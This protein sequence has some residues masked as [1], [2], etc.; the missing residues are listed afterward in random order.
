LP[1]LS[2]FSGN[3][4]STNL[5]PFKLETITLKQFWHTFHYVILLITEYYSCLFLCLLRGP[6]FVMPSALNVQSR[7]FRKNEL[8][9]RQWGK[10]NRALEATIFKRI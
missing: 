6:Y 3:S 4:F 9:F 2:C 7:A 5:P 8:G 10:Q 1:C